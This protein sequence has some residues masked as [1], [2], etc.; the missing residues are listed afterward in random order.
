MTAKTVDFSIQYIMNRTY[1]QNQYCSGGNYESVAS[2]YANQRIDTME[3]TKD[4]P[5]S[6]MMDSDSLTYTTAPDF[7]NSSIPDGQKLNTVHFFGFSASLG[8]CPMS[9]F[10]VNRATADAGFN[11]T[12]ADI[13]KS[14]LARGIAVAAQMNVQGGTD[15]ENSAFNFY[16]S[17]IFNASC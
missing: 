9:T 1:G 12:S 8:G 15:A 7:P 10:Q 17:G 11:G 6:A 4:Y 2:D 14:I 5:Y 13:L 3:L 16:S